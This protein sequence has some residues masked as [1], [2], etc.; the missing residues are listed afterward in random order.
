MIEAQ[1]A[2]ITA[3]AC[4]PAIIIAAWTKMA[5]RD[6]FGYCSCSHH[7]LC[8]MNIELSG[9]GLH[10]EKRID[11]KAVCETLCKHFSGCLKVS[12]IRGYDAPKGHE[13]WTYDGGKGFKHP[14]NGAWVPGVPSV[15]LHEV[16]MPKLHLRKKIATF[17]RDA[18]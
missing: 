2:I 5:C 9:I 18:E 11:R 14:T 3:S 13:D 17:Q 4:L 8:P 1:A 7:D 6:K 10:V 12:H 16:A 15:A